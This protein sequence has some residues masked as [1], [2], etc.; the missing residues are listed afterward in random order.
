MWSTSLTM[1]L[2]INSAQMLIASAA[3]SGDESAANAGVKADAIW[4]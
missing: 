4:A 1:S 3:I 2:D